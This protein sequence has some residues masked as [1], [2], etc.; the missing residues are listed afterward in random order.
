[1]DFEVI[2]L[3]AGAGGLACAH[4]LLKKGVKVVIIEKE[5][6]VGGLMRSV[7]FKDFSVDYGYKNLDN[8]IPDVHHF[9]KELLKDDYSSIEIRTGILYKGNV[10]ELEKKYKGVTRGMSL[11]LLASSV[12]DMLISKLRYRRL[13]TSSLANS[14][15]ARRGKKFTQI[16]S[17]EYSERSR[18]L[19]WSR[20]PAP[21]N[22][23]HSKLL[24]D[25]LS[26]ANKTIPKKGGSFHPNK[27]TGQIIEQLVKEIKQ[28]GGEIYTGCQVTAISHQNNQISNVTVSK[29]DEDVKISGSKFVSSLPLQFVSPLM[30]IDFAP[31]KMELSFKRGVIMVYLF[32]KKPVKFVHNSLRVSCPNVFVSRITNY[33][34]FGGTMIPKG[35]ACLCLEY[36]TPHSKH[37]I[38]LSDQEI[39]ELAISECQKSNLFDKNDCADVLVI[40]NLQA[41]SAQSWE[42]YKM[43]STRKSLYKQLS[44]FENLYQINRTGADK[45]SYAG[46]MA[47]KSIVENNRTEFDELTK[48]DVVSPWKGAI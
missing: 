13:N 22:N 7:K 8:G 17:Q 44:G 45:S 19:K 31:S 38:T 42:D 32:L 34:A 20:I 10:I 46:I 11:G 47:A 40:R 2:I 18:G 21:S 41:D 25:F 23:K 26:D 16:F 36:F 3:G 29:S 9:W 39:K 12:V 35:K 4:S 37:L 28:M 6:E 14:I 27:G 43:D 30:G 15:Y 33:A 1:M 48:P 5:N 24:S